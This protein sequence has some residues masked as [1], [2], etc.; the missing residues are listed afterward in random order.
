MAFVRF[1]HVA[2]ALSIAGWIA[3]PA[4]AQPTTCL[5]RDGMLVNTQ[6]D[7]TIGAMT[8]GFWGTQIN[9]GR[10]YAV[11]AFGHTGDTDLQLTVYSDTNCSFPVT[12]TNIEDV[13]PLNGGLGSTD[14]DAVAFTAGATGEF[15]IRVQNLVAQPTQVRLALIETTLYSPWWY[16]GSPNQSFIVLSNTTAS[17]IS[18]Q[19]TMRGPD[20]AMC[21]TATVALPARGTAFVRVNDYVACLSAGYGS[22]TIDF[23]S[24]PG[25]I[26]ANTTVIDSVGGVSFDEPF[27]PRALWG[28]PVVSR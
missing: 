27:A 9:V 5:A 28:G 24:T 14:L 26:V 3:T 6:A 21:G 2:C 17:A 11:I 1:A 7:V 23:V 12:S 8:F 15:V 4:L 10:S 20:G 13:Q 25:S 22:A 18:P 19:V 16:V